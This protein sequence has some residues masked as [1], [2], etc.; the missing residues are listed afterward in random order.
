MGSAVP[1]ETRFYSSF[2]HMMCGIPPV[3]CSVCSNLS[4][5]DIVSLSFTCKALRSELSPL[6]ARF[7]QSCASQIGGDVELLRSLLKQTNSYLELDIRWTKD[8]VDFPRS[9][10]EVCLVVCCVLIPGSDDVQRRVDM[11]RSFLVGQVGYQVAYDSVSVD[12]EIFLV[13]GY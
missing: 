3:G 12:R 11:I 13:I 1:A 9:F 4:R 10:S 2:V 7:A 6:F 8:S 5:R